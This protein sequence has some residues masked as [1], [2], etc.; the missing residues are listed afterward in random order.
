[1]L[2]WPAFAFRGEA[3]DQAA[4]AE[5]AA[6]AQKGVFAAE[7]MQTPKQ[8]GAVAAAQKAGIAVTWH[9]RPDRPA[10][11]RG[12]NLG[13]RQSF[14]GGKGLLVQ[15]GQ[16]FRED[17]VAVMDN[18][19]DIFRV[20]DA[21]GEFSVMRVDLD[22]AGYNHVRMTQQYK[23]LRVVGSEMIVHFNPAG[24]PYE[25]N[26]E[27]VP[28]IRVDITPT[29]KPSDA[30]RFAQ[31]DLVALGVPQSEL[32]KKPELV[33]YA[34]DVDPVL[35]YELML[36]A[37]AGAAL[38]RYWI[39]AHTGSIL[40]RYNDI[41][42]VSEPTTSGAAAEISGNLLPGEGGEVTNVTGWA[43]STGLYYLF[44][45]VRRWLVKNVSTIPLY[46]DAATYAYRETSDWADSDPAE[47]SAARGF[48]VTQ[49]YYQQVHGQNS[50][51]NKG[52]LAQ[53]NVH[54]GVNY[55][56]AFWDPERKQ[57]FIGDGDGETCDNLA[58]LDVLGHE[59]TH[60]VTENICNLTYAYESGALN[61]S[62][63]DIF[64][65]CIEFR[66]QSDDRAS[67]PEVHPGQADWLIG[68][69]CNLN[70]AVVAMRDMR[71]PANLTTVGAGVQP[72]RYRGTYW[73]TGTDDNG[74]VHANSGVQ[75]FFFYLLCEG[76][77][78][79]NDGVTY[80]ME[81]IG[82]TNA[83]RV[84]YR[85]L[86]YCTSGTNYKM[87]QDA[88]AHAAADL[89]T[90]WV[91]NVRQAWWVA[92]GGPAPAFVMPSTMPLGIV[93]SPYSYALG[94]AGGLSP[95]T[96]EYLSGD[97][98]TGGISFVSGMVS[99][100]P[101]TPGTFT[102]RVA[103]KDDIG[104][105]ITNDFVL[106]IL[107]ANTIPFTETFESAT[108]TFLPLG[109]IQETI[110]NGL[111]WEM[112]NGGY[113]G[114]PAAA[115]GGSIN[116]RFASVVDT[117]AAVARLISPRID[118]GTEA[119]AARLSFWHCMAPSA[120]MQDE[121]RVY[122]RSA[123][124]AEWQLLATYTTAVNTWTLRT[125]DLPGPSRTAYL[126]FLGTGQNG[127]G[128]CIDDVTVWDPTPPLGITTESVLPEAVTEVPY[129]LTFAAEGGV[130][131]YTYAL[132]SG[133]LPDGF[134]FFPEGLITGFCT[135]V[136]SAEFTL[137]LT[138]GDGK[139]ATK[140]FSLA[141]SK[142]RAD[143]YAEDF[144]YASQM[145]T[146]WTQEYVTNRI[147]WAVNQGGWIKGNVK[148]PAA[149][150]SGNYNM[151]FF[152]SAWTDG[153]S[154]D[155]KTK[156]VSP[157]IDLGQAPA[158][159]KLTFWHCMEG[160]L[161][162]G[163]P[164]QD[165]LRVFYRA[166][167]NEAWTS[168][169]EFT[170]NVATWTQRSILLPNPTSTY[171]IAFEGNAHFGYGVC[172]DGI[173]ISD[174][175][176]APIITT[177]LALPNGLKGQPYTSTLA[178]VGGVA[179]YTWTVVSNA[180]P[181][182]LSLDEATGVISGT[183]TVACVKTFGVKVAGFDGRATTNVF[184]LRIVPPGQ[185]PYT[186][187][188][189]NGGGIPEGWTDL[190]MSGSAAWTFLAGSPAVL[191]GG[192]PVAAHTGAYN[193]CLFSG[194]PNANNYRRLISPMLNLGVGTTNATLSFWL[195]MDK[196]SIWQDHLNVCYKSSPS[197]E[198]TVL[199][200]FMTEVPEWTNI[201][202]ALPNPSTTYYIAFEGCAMFGSGICIDDVVVNGD[203]VM[204][205]YEVWKADVFGAD[206]GNDLIAGDEAD[207]DRDGIVNALEYA[208]GLDPMTIDTEG[209]PTGGVTAGYLTLSFRM[210]K[211]ALDAG[212]LYEVEACTDLLLQDWST[213]NISALPFGDSNQWWQAAFQHDVP[214]T[215]APQRF[216]RFK[217]TLPTP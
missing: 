133:S 137:Q 150:A 93:G 172:I 109:W 130:T 25:A 65:T 215:N 120:T 87:V 73:H 198:W 99:G 195:C 53:V 76:G 209:L 20:Q 26:G 146:G 142:P 77:S 138:D 190:P 206:A 179:P 38:W 12:P 134:F 95:C 52:L 185:L 208:M 180:L 74:G 155:Q 83:E 171:Q 154:Y 217:V 176:D 27:Y 113:D 23:G 211:D 6:L 103:A 163:V 117:N 199:A 100:M 127:H 80:T 7:P 187:T 159:I 4:Q 128:V 153:A 84:A 143:I 81:G 49:E 186:E 188:F 14:S 152:S 214:V 132:F 193:A 175:T 168:L 156:L 151:W 96:Y 178:A 21:A 194:T 169:A 41:K 79:I 158:S 111:P 16:A 68:E 205:A 147:S 174:A 182:G 162:S 61:E 140:D 108:N 173:R 125:L 216:M 139:T 88:W 184:L 129:S 59:F 181:T 192:L 97:L 157:V 28:E 105:A 70:T 45:P 200:S 101:E 15:G 116:A 201:V 118:F 104:Q 136:Q 58:V 67:Y 37:Q 164:Q 148:H 63:S 62:F 39:D 165:E 210:D 1:M 114:S 149:A 50:F 18:L 69:D 213:S 98:P 86:R 202:I 85:T 189:E 191:E 183:G 46:T 115:H 36:R 32:K 107:P 197:A 207:P 60:A 3:G 177:G 42:K 56:N 78:G 75:N 204:S 55:A 135:T 145:P 48:D 35:A 196:F 160:V 141:V 167:T 161:D 119:K 203:V 5:S 102:F 71:D 112:V 17:A 33:V 82:I 90:N 31:T 51:D 19:S 91:R 13:M 106:T 124:D 22:E 44:S 144:E 110:T 40:F 131:N 89:N 2:A 10:S 122:Y 47:M 24:I 8:A 57:F 92:T 212:V 94:I 66:G 64:G 170:A 43:E 166:A 9:V 54:E 34:R 11:V 121:L 123:L 126:A 29:V 30:I 72:S